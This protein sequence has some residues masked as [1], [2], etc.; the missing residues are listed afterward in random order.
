[1]RKITTGNQSKKI[2]ILHGWMHS[3]KRYI[4]FAKALSNCSCD[5]YDFAGF[6]NTPVKYKSDII[7]NYAI[8]L[9]SYLLEN[10]YD[11]IIAHSM[12]GSVL[13]RA[14][15][16]MKN[17]YEGKL[18]FINPEYYGITKIIPLVFVMPIV[19]ILLKLTKVMPLKLIEPF[20]KIAALF[21]VNS[22][23]NIDNVIIEDVLDAD[24]LVA[25]ILIK[26]MA[27][28]KWRVAKYE[29]FKN[30]WLLESEKDRIISHKK[31]NILK[32][33]LKVKD[34]YVFKKGHTP[35]VEEFDK[36]LSKV[37]EILRV[38]L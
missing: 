29:N 38:N 6:G 30:V 18:I 36:L 9:Q 13:L 27:F 10:K 1:M 11:C 34:Y 32:K 25:T 2:L 16:K 7:D 35:V 4:K 19:F 21:T 15:D 33:D 23:N 37:N 3:S 5:L 14:I 22:W 20:I 24:S 17:K 26:E 28:D 12:G 8:E 31:L